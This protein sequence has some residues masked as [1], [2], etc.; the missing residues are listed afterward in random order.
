MT[1]ADPVLAPKQSTLVVAPAV[2]T[3]VTG[4]VI[5]NVCVRVHPFASVIVQ[6]YDPAKIAAA[7]AELPPL[8]DQEYV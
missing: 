1:D 3:T 7:V 2:A 4:S 8:G 6:V 5:W